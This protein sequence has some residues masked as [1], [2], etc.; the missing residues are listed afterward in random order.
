MIQ[1]LPNPDNVPGAVTSG[2][3]RQ[4]T[5]MY[6]IQTGLDTTE[7]YDN[8]EGAI[9]IPRG[10]VVELNGVMYKIAD[11]V[12]LQ[13]PNA[14]IAYWI[15]M[16]TNDVGAATARLVTRPGKWFPAKQ[17]CYDNEGRR[18]LNWVSLGVPSSLND[19]VEGV[20]IREK[21]VTRNADIILKKGWYFINMGSGAGN[22]AGSRG[23]NADTGEALIVNEGRAI[24]KVNKNKILFLENG[25]YK[26]SVG[27]DG[28]DGSR[29]AR[30]SSYA[31]QGGG[32]G[33]SAGEETIFDNMT[34]GISQPGI[35]GKG[36]RGRLQD[37][38][39]GAAGGDPGENGGSLN[40]DNV[41]GL[42]ND[43]M[44]GGGGGAGGNALTYYGKGGDGGRFKFRTEG[45]KNSGYLFIYQ[46]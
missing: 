12:T 41:G 14:A 8:G 38:V 20:L 36:G 24:Q 22:G 39:E 32:G 46:L 23:A 4:N 40:A 45:D 17:G 44:S 6:A 1:I 21:N 43:F 35:G 10:G 11:E 3:Q 34:T 27:G 18:T 31:G 13:K 9:T 30:A 16:E 29:G 33:S 15:A 25:N 2:Y 28:F 7:P 26:Y 42:S 37:G 5:N 19:S